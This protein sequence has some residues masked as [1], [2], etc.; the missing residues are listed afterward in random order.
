M[1]RK[2]TL[3]YKSTPTPELDDLEYDDS[4]D[5][6][7]AWSSSFRKPVRNPKERASPKPE[8]TVTRRAKERCRKGALRTRVTRPSNAATADEGPSP[9]RMEVNKEQEGLQYDDSSDAEDAWSSSFRKP[10]E[11][12]KGR[13]SPEPENTV[14]ARS[15]KRPRKGAL[16]TRRTRR[17]AEYDQNAGPGPTPIVIDD[18]AVLTPTS[19][20]SVVDVS[21]VSGDGSVPEP[22]EERE[23]STVVGMKV[24]NIPDTHFGREDICCHACLDR[25]A[26]VVTLPCGHIVMCELCA[27]HNEMLDILNR[28]DQCRRGC[29]SCRA[30][31]RQQSLVVMP[32]NNND[33]IGYNEAVKKAKSALEL[34]YLG[35]ARFIPIFFPEYPRAERV[36]DVIYEMHQRYLDNNWIDIQRVAEIDEIRYMQWLAEPS[37]DR[38]DSEDPTYV[39]VNG[40]NM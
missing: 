15:M 16:R 25:Y 23:Y 40:F 32:Y 19:A 8:D 7:D 3:R 34:A 36:K 38:S 6:E 30:E 5:A 27:M 29:M 26:N 39:D 24:Q 9:V 20:H 14:P 4:S 10:L 2:R 28:P 33:L 31:I 21:S 35:D 1:E 13:A 12:P 37:S 22:V 18:H 11:N 17:T